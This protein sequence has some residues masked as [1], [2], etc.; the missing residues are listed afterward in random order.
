MDRPGEGGGAWIQLLSQILTP[1]PRA[2]R[3]PQHIAVKD[4]IETFHLPTARRDFYHF[5]PK[6]VPCVERQGEDLR[7]KGLEWMGNF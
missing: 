1:I 3:R 7:K 5:L 2:G 4:T 6:C